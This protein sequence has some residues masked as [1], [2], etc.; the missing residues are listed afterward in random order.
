MTLFERLRGG[1]SDPTATAISA[2]PATKSHAVAESSSFSSSRLPA[3][4][5]ENFDE[6]TDEAMLIAS[7]AIAMAALTDEQRL[8]QLADLQSDPAIARFWALVWP[9]ARSAAPDENA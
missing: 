7:R 4:D 2:N 9:E 3:N 5:D 8:A 1:S 6:Y